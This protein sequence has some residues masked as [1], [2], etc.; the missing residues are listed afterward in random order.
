MTESGVSPCEKRATLE[1]GII[2]SALVETAVPVDETPLPEAPIEFVAWLRTAFAAIELIEFF[3]E[4]EVIVPATAL[5]ACEPLAGPPV[6]LT[7]T[8][9]K[10]CGFCQ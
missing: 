8:S 6:V 2:V 9:F 7:Q 4:G 1:S 5:V 3:C 10:V